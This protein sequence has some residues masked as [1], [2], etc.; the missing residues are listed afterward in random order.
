MSEVSSVYQ[1]DR[2]Y[3]IIIKLEVITMSSSNPDVLRMSKLNVLQDEPVCTGVIDKSFRLNPRLFSFY[4][5]GK[6][7]F[8][9]RA[10]RY[11]LDLNPGHTMDITKGSNQGPLSKR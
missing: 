5:M 2:N 6:N 3:G 4:S 10:G 1:I 8:P 7:E 11:S 9:A